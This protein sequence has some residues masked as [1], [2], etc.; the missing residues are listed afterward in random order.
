M[1]E[2]S[3]Q[4]ALVWDLIWS[5]SSGQNGIYRQAGLET[6]RSK[7][8]GGWFIR[9]KEGAFFYPDPKHE[10]NGRSLD[11]IPEK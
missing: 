10:W 9:C 8:P 1:N 5:V 4:K 2:M 7:V 3:E 11:Y 6:Y